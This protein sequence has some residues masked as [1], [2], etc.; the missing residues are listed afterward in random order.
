[1]FTP[2]ENQEKLAD[3]L[4][5]KDFE[6]EMKLGILLCCETDEQAKKMLEFCLANPELED[7]EY[8]E[9]AVDISNGKE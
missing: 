4:K 6:K 3:Y 9:K 1:M 7:Y 2:T 8:L 5:Q